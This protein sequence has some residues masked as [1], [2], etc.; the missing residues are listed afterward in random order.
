MGSMWKQS[1]W[2]KGLASPGD[3]LVAAVVGVGVA[4]S[5]AALMVVAQVTHLSP[6]PAPLGVAFA[7]T[8]LPSGSLGDHGLLWV[9]LGLHVAYVT[10]ATVAYVAVLRSRLGGVAAFGWALGLW[11]FAGVVFAPL[12][13]WGL[14]ASGTGAGGFVNLLAVHLAYGAFLWAGGWVAFRE[15]APAATQIVP[16]SAPVGVGGLA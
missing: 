12:V 11:V 10:S 5:L 3:L 7:K 6:L 16:S 13:G 1:R 2:L 8:V 14:F 15:T 9:G 4:L